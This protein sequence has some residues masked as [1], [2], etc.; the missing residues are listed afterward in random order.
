MVSNIN[1]DDYTN[2][3]THCNI[4]MHC[5]SLHILK[6][7]NTATSGQKTAMD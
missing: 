7:T 5:I 4:Y 1:C 2:L 6:V 3:G